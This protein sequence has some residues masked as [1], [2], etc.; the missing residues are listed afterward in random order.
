DRVEQLG[1]QVEERLNEPGYLSLVEQGFRTW[2]EATTEDKRAYV[3]RILANA[4]GTKI[5]SDDLVR[6][7]LDWITS[8]HEAHFLVIREVYKKAGSTRA[9][10][11]HAIHRVSVREDSADAD[12]FKLL[13][14]ELSMG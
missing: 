11:W 8:Y 3:R 4:A 12:L 2:N 14:R 13:I 6:L 1:P 9:E 5:C 7:F 10:V